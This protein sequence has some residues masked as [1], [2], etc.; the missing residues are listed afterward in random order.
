MH[1]PNNIVNALNYVGGIGPS[2][3]QDI[4]TGVADAARGKAVW[5]DMESSLR[6]TLIEKNG[7]TKDV[8]SIDKCFQCILI[9]TKN[10]NLPV[11]RFT[12]L[13]I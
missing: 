12:I 2:T 9:G 6:V 3:I 1:A 11:S 5:I 10:F 7:A 8:F 4:M 13:S